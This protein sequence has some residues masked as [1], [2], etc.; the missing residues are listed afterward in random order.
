[1]A[2]ENKSPVR[3]CTRS[4]CSLIEILVAVRQKDHEDW[5]V[6]VKVSQSQ[7][8]AK[9]LS[10]RKWKQKEGYALRCSGDLRETLTD[11]HEVQEETQTRDLGVS[12]VM[13][14]RGMQLHQD[15]GCITYHPGHTRGSWLK[16][17]QQ[18]EEAE[19]TNK[20]MEVLPKPWAHWGEPFKKCAMC[21]CRKLGV[22]VWQPV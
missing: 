8:A 20:L 14:R 9:F 16:I 5:V 1:M 15:S 7:P 4:E 10:N 13:R 22:S 2:K 18:Y 12:D 3:Q 21:Y 19:G 11:R 17:A 6:M